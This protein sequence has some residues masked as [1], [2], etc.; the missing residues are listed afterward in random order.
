MARRSDARA[1]MVLIPE[2]S[3]KSNSAALPLVRAERSNGRPPPI[4]TLPPS[5]A[6]GLPP[7]PSSLP[8]PIIIQ[9]SALVSSSTSRRSSSERSR[10][11]SRTPPSVI[12]PSSDMLISAELPESPPLPSVFS[13]DTRAAVDGMLS[14]P[15]QNPTSQPPLPEADFPTSHHSVLSIHSIPSQIGRAHV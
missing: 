8:S 12:P 7:L 5:G 9:P 10:A 2:S 13:T 6:P 1:P 15:T 11:R 14:S 4:I 3:S